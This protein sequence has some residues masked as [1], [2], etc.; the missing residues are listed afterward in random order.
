M[1]GSYVL[2]Q[3]NLSKCLSLFAVLC[4]NAIHILMY[5]IYFGSVDDV[6]TI[7]NVKERSGKHFVLFK[8]IYST[9]FSFL[10]LQFI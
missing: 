6:I 2:C 3:V 5:V 9:S 10:F 1:P 7:S 4:F 8:T